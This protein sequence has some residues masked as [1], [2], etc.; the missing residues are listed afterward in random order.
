MY[1]VLGNIVIN[2]NVFVGGHVRTN[3]GIQSNVCPDVNL[4]D[5]STTII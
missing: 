4:S 1:C 3:S 2:N 5:V